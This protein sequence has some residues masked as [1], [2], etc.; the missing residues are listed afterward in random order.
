VGAD[1]D[2]YPEKCPPLYRLTTPAVYF[3][4]NGWEQDGVTEGQLN[5]NL[6]CD[7]FVVVDAAGAGVSRP[8]IFLR[9]ATARILP[10]GL[11]ASCSA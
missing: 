4:I 11:T 1:A 2:A 9:T 10:S 5:V 3:S 6:S 8:E 7:L